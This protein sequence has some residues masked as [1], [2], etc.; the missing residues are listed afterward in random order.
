MK[1]FSFYKIL[2][3]DNTSLRA[4]D[5]PLKLTY[6]LN[7]WTFP[8]IGKLFVYYDWYNLIDSPNIIV[9][10]CEVLNP[11]FNIRLDM[12]IPSHK[13]LSDVNLIK[14]FWQTM[15]LEKG[16]EREYF[17]TDVVWCDAV[18]LIKKK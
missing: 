18:K 10:E 9:Y 13:Y 14:K 6:K 8:T 7:K 11:R 17:G 5:G 2:R 16:I 4:P 12:Q 1:Y 15:K 3:P